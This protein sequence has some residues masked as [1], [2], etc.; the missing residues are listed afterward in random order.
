MKLISKAIS[1]LALLSTLIGCTGEDE[2][3]F[4]QVDCL[5]DLQG[6][7]YQLLDQA[8]SAGELY[9][10]FGNDNF[11]TFSIDGDS[12]L[13]GRLECSAEEIVIISE[14]LQS[15][16]LN[17]RVELLNQ[18]DEILVI[19]DDVSEN[20]IEEHRMDRMGACTSE[21]SPVCARDYA[22][23]DSGNC[24]GP[25]CESFVYR[26]FGNHC[27]AVASHAAI[28]FNGECGDL[29]GTKGYVSANIDDQDRSCTSIYDPVCAVNLDEQPPAYRTYSNSCEAG[30]NS[31]IV[32]EERCGRSLENVI[33]QFDDS[34]VQ[35]APEEPQE[36]TSAHSQTLSENQAKWQQYASGDYAYTFSLGCFCAYRGPALVVYAGGELSSIVGIDGT[37]VPVYAA[38]QFS[39]SAKIENLFQELARAYEDGAEVI[40]VIYHPQYGYPESLYIDWS[41]QLADDETQYSI[42][43]FELKA[44]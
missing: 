16:S 5:S 17:V 2:D 21:Y 8:L 13:S 32:S 25:D 1:V 42:T 4:A 23:A 7:R 36:Q 37:P 3:V 30:I 31:I 34:Q 33:Y 41:S 26:T 19:V 14:A 24:G 10:E 29:E 22:E 12:A 38:S 43:D 28:S 15:E 11:V 40:N 6:S 9:I 27:E 20:S 18:G 44:I 35:Q 39:Q